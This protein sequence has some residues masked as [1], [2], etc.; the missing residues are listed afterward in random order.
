MSLCHPV[1][2]LRLFTFLV[3]LCLSFILL[4]P[5]LIH[6]LRFSSSSSSLTYSSSSPKKLVFGVILPNNNSY[7]W[8]LPKTRFAVEFAI[9][10]IVRRQ[11]L[12]R[13]RVKALYRDSNCSDTDGPLEAIDMYTEKVVNVF[14]GPACDYAVAPIARFTKRWEIP[15]ITAGALVKAFEN[16]EEYRLLTRLMG[17]Y[18]KM[19]EAVTQMCRHFRWKKI[20]M[21]YHDFEDVGSRSDF[22]F[23]AESLFWALTPYSQGKPWFAKFDEIITQ[24]S[25]YRDMLHEAG[26]NSRITL[27]VAPP[28]M[29]ALPGL[30]GVMDN[31]QHDM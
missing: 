26:L 18:V 20:G 27:P 15:V 7:Y 1:S 8:S 17:T 25:T 6:T 30:S 23:I 19:A 11:L 10:T 31:A 3:P 22:F 24:E 21:L 28:A 5:G 13:W 9:K 2:T 16:K 4:Y 14:L 29:Q 12:P